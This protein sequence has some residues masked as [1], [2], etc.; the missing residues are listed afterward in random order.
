MKLQEIESWDTKY[1]DDL[2]YLKKS[3]PDLIK[4]A[5]F[6]PRRSRIQRTEKRSQSGVILFGKKAEITPGE[7]AFINACL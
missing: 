6:I 1:Q 5:L 2:Y 3:Q 7:A 4:K